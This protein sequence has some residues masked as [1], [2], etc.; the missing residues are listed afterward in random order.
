MACGFGMAAV[1]ALSRKMPTPLFRGSFS[2]G[3]E[4]TMDGVVPEEEGAEQP[5]FNLRSTTY[6]S[7][8]ADE[9]VLEGEVYSDNVKEGSDDED[10]S[11]NASEPMQVVA[12]TRT[13]SCDDDFPDASDYLDPEWIKNYNKLYIAD[14]DDSDDE[15]EYA[16]ESDTDEMYSGPL[17]PVRTTARRD[18]PHPTKYLT[19]EEFVDLRSSFL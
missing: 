3:K 5:S 15:S 1:R 17:Q 6:E 9:R 14:S 11:S 7:A 18:F 13:L 19:K 16:E 2:M 8:S 10:V 12:R 4:K